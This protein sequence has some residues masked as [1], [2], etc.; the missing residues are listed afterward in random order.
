MVVLGTTIHEFRCAN[1]A[2]SDKLM[3]P[4]AKAVGA[5]RHSSARMTDGF[6]STR[7]NQL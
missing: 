4:R 2:G 5:G 6:K 1:L 7:S 3:N